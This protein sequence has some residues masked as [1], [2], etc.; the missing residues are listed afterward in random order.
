[1]SPLIMCAPYSE[2]PTEPNGASHKY[3]RIY[4]TSNY[5][6]N[7]VGLAEIEMA[8]SVGGPDLCVGGATAKYQ[9]YY[10]DGNPFDGNLSYVSSSTWLGP[11]PTKLPAIIGYNFASPVSV[12]EIRMVGLNGSDAYCWG[13]SPNAFQVQHS[14]DNVNWTTAASFSS[15]GP[16]PWVKAEMRGFDIDS[17][18]IT[19]TGGAFGDY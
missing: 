10:W 15:G 18:S 12:R 2:T 9:T 7:L 13:R 6:G 4:V 17:G 14:D 5:G 16:S 1:M 19:F 11:Y 3:W 8:A